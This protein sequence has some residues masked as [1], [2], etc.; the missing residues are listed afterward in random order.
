M[1]LISVI[2]PV[3][4]VEA[5]LNRCV[6][7]IVNQSYSNLEI[8][9][10]DD[11]SP[12]RCP[13]MCDAWGQKDK[14][15]KV[16]HK[17][18]GGLSD[19]RNAGMAAA[20]GHFTAFIDSDDWIDPEMLSRLHERMIETDS[21]IVSCGAVR[22][23]DNNDIQ[24]PMIADAGNYILDKTEAMRALI[25]SSCLIQTV[26]NKL[27]KTAIIKEIP[28]EVGKIHEDEFWSWQAVAAS[29]HIATIEDNLYYYYQRD[30]SIMGNGSYTES[31]MLVLEAKSQRYRYIR[32]QMADLEDIATVDL[33]YTCYYQGCQ[34]V[35][36]ME[37][38]EQKVYFAKI[39]DIVKNCEIKS[40]YMKKL[41]LIKQIRLFMIQHCLE[42][43]CKF[44]VLIG[45]N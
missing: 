39:N 42:K 15:V 1:D 38:K 37:P 45:L 9:L 17:E 22:V 21:D 8:I 16:I 40:S 44:D 27:Y 36:N 5:Y 25:Q 13:E 11:G 33:L 12:D 6:E 14:R 19:A 29:H 43:M 7:S 3:Y 20:K 26:W 41:R 4:N 28:F 10:V 30:N 31:P 2:V 35:K 32:D 23:W 34:I 18:N 24:K